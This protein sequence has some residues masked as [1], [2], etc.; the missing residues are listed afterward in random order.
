MYGVPVYHSSEYTVVFGLRVWGDEV[1]YEC[2]RQG[3]VR[4]SS[5]GGSSGGGSRI[6]VVLCASSRTSST[7]VYYP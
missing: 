4:G 6:A 1:L 3:Y 5:G 7:M 2:P